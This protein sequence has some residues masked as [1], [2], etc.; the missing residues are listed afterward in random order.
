MHAYIDE[1]GSFVCTPQSRVCAVGALAIPSA[2]RDQLFVEFEHFKKQ[3]GSAEPELKGSRLTERQ[4][5]RVIGMLLGHD[6]LLDVCVVDMGLERDAITTRFKHE[7][8]D[9]L[10]EHL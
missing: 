8:A 4:V 5:A 1:S 6:A 10:F 9:A 7:Q 3:V 2:A